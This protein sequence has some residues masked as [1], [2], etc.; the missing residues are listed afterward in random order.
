MQLSN[1]EFIVAVH[2]VCGFGSEAFF[3]LL[4]LNF[5]DPDSDLVFFIYENQENLGHQGFSSLGTERWCVQL[6][7]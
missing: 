1:D 2:Q 3:D 5:S 6:F 4:A 7:P